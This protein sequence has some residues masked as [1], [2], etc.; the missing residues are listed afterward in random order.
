MRSILK[1]VKLDQQLLGDAAFGPDRREYLCHGL[2][3]PCESQGAVEPG[4]QR[5]WYLGWSQVPL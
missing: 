3:S 1:A 2:F 5:I 4:W